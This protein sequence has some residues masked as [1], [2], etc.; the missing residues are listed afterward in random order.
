[1]SQTPHANGSCLQ[2]EK[3]ITMRREKRWIFLAPKKKKTAACET[4]EE[5]RVSSC[6]QRLSFCRS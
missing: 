5:N 1:L 3:K 4:P 2:L 6:G